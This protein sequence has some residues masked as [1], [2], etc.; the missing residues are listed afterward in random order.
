MT[1]EHPRCKDCYTKARPCPL[2]EQEHRSAKFLG[3]RRYKSNLVAVGIPIQG[4]F[5]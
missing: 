4:R 5:K 3:A 1:L 2:C